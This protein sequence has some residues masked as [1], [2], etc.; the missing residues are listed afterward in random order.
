M[1]S[2]LMKATACDCSRPHV[3]EVSTDLVRMSASLRMRAARLSGLLTTSRQ[4]H[5]LCKHTAVTSTGCVGWAWRTSGWS[6]QDW[7]AG[8]ASLHLP[9]WGGWLH[10]ACFV[11][12]DLLL[13]GQ[14]AM[15]PSMNWWGPLPEPGWGLFW[16]WGLG[17]STEVLP[18][19]TQVLRL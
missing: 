11:A 16:F 13:P 15:P 19:L 1:M 5:W 2:V 14:S 3:P 10:P 7:Q 8:P 18:Q 12:P 9:E 6:C 17:C 4:L